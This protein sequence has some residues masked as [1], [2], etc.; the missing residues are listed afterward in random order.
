MSRTSAR[1]LVSRIAPTVYPTISGNSER[2]L[3]LAP[4]GPPI[5]AQGVSP[6]KRVATTT[7]LSPR[8]GATERPVLNGSAVPPGLKHRTSIAARDPGLTP[9]AI[10]WRPLPG[11][12]EALIAD[13]PFVN[14]Q[15]P[16]ACPPVFLISAQNTHWRT[17][18]DSTELAEVQ[19]HPPIR[20]VCSQ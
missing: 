12:P 3:L 18:R 15:I 20:G 19:C 10:F 5:I 16:A 6:G 2:Q 9:W 1:N 4:E 14:S 8:Q 13:N 7:V 17:S 11:A